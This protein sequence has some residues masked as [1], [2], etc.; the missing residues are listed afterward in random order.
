MTFQ[1]GRRYRF[2]GLEYIMDEGNGAIL[3]IKEKCKK[4]F[5][6]IDW[7]FRETEP[8]TKRLCPG[9]CGTYQY[10]YNTNIQS[11]KLLWEVK[12]IKATIMEG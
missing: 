1:V 3:V 4:G 6:H 5:F 9:D 11:W 8:N 10:K 2:S 7:L 12:D